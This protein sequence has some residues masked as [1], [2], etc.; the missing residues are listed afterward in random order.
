MNTYAI[1]MEVRG[2]ETFLVLR[3]E[4]EE[5]LNEYLVK[6]L[7]YNSIAGIL[8]LKSQYMNG[9]TVLNYRIENRC[10]LLDL[11]SQNRLTCKEAKVIYSRLADAMKGMS[12]YFLNADQCIYDVEYLYVD[13]TLNPY[14]PYIPFAKSENQDINKI[15]RDFFLSL[16]SYFS[17]GKQET[18]YDKLMRYLIQPNFSLNEF[19]EILQDDVQDSEPQIVSVKEQ[20]LQN[21]AR[22]SAMSE[23]EKEQEEEAAKTVNGNGAAGGIL[24]PGK[25]TGSSVFDTSGKARVQIPLSTAGEPQKTKSGKKSKSWFGL[26]KKKKDQEEAEE[27]KFPLKFSTPVPAKMPVQ[28][29][30]NT[31]NGGKGE[32]DEWSKTVMIRPDGEDKTVKLKTEQPHLLN[33]EVY[34]PVAQFPFSIGKA[35]ASYIVANPT[36][37]RLHATIIQQSDGYYIIDEESSNGTYVN[38]KRLVPKMPEKLRNQ[39]KLLLSDEEFVFYTG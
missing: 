10:R 23:R 35:S 8:P 14:L 4:Q 13:A 5:A 7:E 2:T 9:K 22:I 24:I 6:M 1:T 16:L 25:A 29:G 36:V 37:S 27:G 39:D 32:D 38:G 26:G 19:R 15:R 28:N 34:I 12:E 21:T 30:R 33:H 31:V 3:Q 17:N 20:M 18:F 11:I